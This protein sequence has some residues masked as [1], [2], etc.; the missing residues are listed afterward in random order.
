MHALGGRN[1][2]AW[3]PRAGSWLTGLAG[4]HACIHALRK[5][6]RLACMLTSP[7]QSAGPWPLAFLPACLQL[8]TS[9]HACM[10]RP[11]HGQGACIPAYC[12]A[13]CRLTSNRAGR[14]AC[15]WACLRP[16]DGMHVCLLSS[17][18]AG[19]SPCTRRLVALRTGLHAC[20]HAY[21][22]AYLRQPANGPVCLLSG[23]LLQV[24]RDSVSP[25][26]GQG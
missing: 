22:H 19:S 20:V 9:P 13:F 18:L 1:G 11:P 5:T 10:H 15:L 2:Q 16:K 12:L 25:H 23:A 24:Q 14:H 6:A 21:M 4:W 3:I 26:A 8:K 7:S 17:Q